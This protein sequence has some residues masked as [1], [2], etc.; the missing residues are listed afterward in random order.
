MNSQTS[1]EKVE[2]SE[3]DSA[4]FQSGEAGKGTS[5]VDIFVKEMMNAS[6]LGDMRGRAMKILEAF[7]G[8]VVAQTT[9]VVEVDNFEHWILLR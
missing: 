6:D 2:V 4:D 9:A 7:E 5:W 8:D 3:N 1:G